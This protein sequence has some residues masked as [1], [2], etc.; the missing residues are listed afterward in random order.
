MN[1]YMSPILDLKDGYY[2]VT[3]VDGSSWAPTVTRIY[4]SGTTEDYINLSSCGEYGPRYCCNSP[5]ES[6]ASYFRNVIDEGGT[7]KSISKV[8]FEALVEL[9]K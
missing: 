6:S 7:I 9:Y 3:P 4:K 2:A 5:I 8:Q 1:L